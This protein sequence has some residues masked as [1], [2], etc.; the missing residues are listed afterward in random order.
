MLQQAGAVVKTALIVP[1][2]NAAS[3]LP[4]LLEELTVVFDSRDILVVDDG[5]TDGTEMVCRDAGIAVI[6]HPVNIGKGAALRVGFSWSLARGYNAVV[7]LDADGQH[8]GREIA[9][10]IKAA[11]TGRAGVI[12]GSRMDRPDGMPWQRRMSNRITSWVVSRRIGQT[13]RDSQSGFRLIRSEVLRSVTLETDRFQTESELLIKAG[14]CGFRI[15]AIPIR[16]IYISSRSAIRPWGDT[17]RFVVLMVKSLFW[18]RGV[19]Q[20][21]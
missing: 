16:S 19:A 13:I 17:W 5:S 7:T 14:L 21:G 15:E 12:V 18:K 20:T 2:F 8:D 10:F 6:R 3:T 1:A 11:Q 9:R 4:R